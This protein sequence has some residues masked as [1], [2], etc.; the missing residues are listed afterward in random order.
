MVG[1]SLERIEGDGGREGAD[2][3]PSKAAAAVE[4]SALRRR[5]TS[6]VHLV[7]PSFPPA[8]RRAARSVAGSRDY[9]RFILATI[10]LNTVLLAL[11]HHGISPGF[12]TVLDSGNFVTTLVFLVDMVISNV[13]LGMAYWR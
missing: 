3:A 8:W 13:A 5:L 12:Q 4:E 10:A 9:G 7:A 6:V 1:Q 11:D 2:G